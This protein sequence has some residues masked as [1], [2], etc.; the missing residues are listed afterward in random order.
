M[1][2]LNRLITGHCYCTDYWKLPHGQSVDPGTGGCPFQLQPAWLA[3][4]HY[5][6]NVTTSMINHHD[7]DHRVENAVGFDVIGSNPFGLPWKFKF[8]FGCG[9]LAMLCVET[10]RFTPSL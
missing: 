5:R 3:S 9:A 4:G 8:A 2:R 1:F 6:I 10:A 7:W